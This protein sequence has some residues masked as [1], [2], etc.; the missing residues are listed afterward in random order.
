MPAPAAVEGRVTLARGYHRYTL[1]MLQPQAPESSPCLAECRPHSLLMSPVAA[2][3]WAGG[4]LWNIMGALDREQMVKGQPH[5]K[6]SVPWLCVCSHL[7]AL[8]P[9]PPAWL[10]RK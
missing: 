1:E 3:G 8:H 7:T 10:Q 9:S 2:M 4:L 6:V 5:A